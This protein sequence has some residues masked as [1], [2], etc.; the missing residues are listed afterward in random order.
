[1]SH[2]RCP[3]TQLWMHSLHVNCHCP[4]VTLL[5]SSPH[6]AGDRVML[7]VPPWLSPNLTSHLCLCG[8]ILLPLGWRLWSSPSP[9]SPHSSSNGSSDPQSFS[10][11]TAH[12]ASFR[13]QL[14]CS[15]RCVGFPNPR[16]SPPTGSAGWSAAPEQK[17]PSPWSSAPL[18]LSYIW[19][20]PTMLYT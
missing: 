11:L 15:S 6:P 12:G 10:R 17:P 9:A 18:S 13:A 7:T 5:L 4:Q 3:D 2:V 8:S 1:M 16:R 19:V 14:S 20:L